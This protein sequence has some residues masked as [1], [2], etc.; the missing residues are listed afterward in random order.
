M[1]REGSY[2][3][4]Y[5]IAVGHSW[6]SKYSQCF[7]L[8]IFS[9]SPSSNALP[10]W[11]L[12][13]QSAFSKYAQFYGK[14]R[15]IATEWILTAC[16]FSCFVLE[17]LVAI[18]QQILDVEVHLYH[19]KD[20]KYLESHISSLY[21]RR[22]IRNLSPTENISSNKNFISGSLWVWTYKCFAGLLHYHLLAA[23]LP[24]PGRCR[25][26]RQVDFSCALHSIIWKLTLSCH[27]DIVFSKGSLQTLY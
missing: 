14:A 6:S 1:E 18:I 3:Q 21:G 7:L 20:R 17:F 26:K 22:K 11:N 23:C 25:A 27:K 9:G 12:C 4:G 19:A 13:C 16:L 5:R 15:L 2:L 24:F 10:H 8:Q